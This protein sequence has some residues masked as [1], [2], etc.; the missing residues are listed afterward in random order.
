[1]QG[2][3]AELLAARELTS[4]FYNAQFSQA[5][6]SD[7]VLSAS[8]SVGS[9]T[10]TLTAVSGRSESGGRPEVTAEGGVRNA[11]K[12]LLGDHRS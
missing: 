4:G 11:T 9:G 2:T 6:E 7:D 12:A 3:H 8:G 1:M 10:A 5:V